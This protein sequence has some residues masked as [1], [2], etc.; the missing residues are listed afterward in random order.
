MKTLI[1]AIDAIRGLPTGMRVEVN[2]KGGFKLHAYA[3]G[4]PG[5]PCKRICKAVGFAGLPGFFVLEL[6]RPDTCL[7]WALTQ[8]DAEGYRRATGDFQTLEEAVA[9]TERQRMSG[10]YIETTEG[11]PA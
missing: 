11:R 2:I 7:F 10:A 8:L 5:E 4:A 3:E 9:F 6:P 1:D